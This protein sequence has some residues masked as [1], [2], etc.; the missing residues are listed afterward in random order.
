METLKGIDIILLYRVLNKAKREAAWKMVF[1]TEH[2][3][4]MTREADSAAT[5]DGNV[6]TLSPV[7]YDFSATS[8]IAQ[9]DPHIDEMKHALLDGEIVEIWEINK[10][11]KGTGEN[12]EKYKAT[13]YQGCVSEFTPTAKA[14]ESVEL[15]LAFAI[16]G[17]GQDGYASLTK[18]QLDV[19][20]Y[21]FSDTLKEQVPNNK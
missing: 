11:E 21:A 4:S 14:E 20:Q 17:V 16:N 2:S 6:Q 13:Y 7:A 8:L 18:E 5:K 9:N 10:I 12:K 3:N 15:E 19:I 1:Q